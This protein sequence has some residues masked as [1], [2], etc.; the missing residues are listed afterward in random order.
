MKEVNEAKNLANAAP[1]VSTIE[2]WIGQAKGMPPK[3]SH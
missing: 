1:A 3:I 2:N